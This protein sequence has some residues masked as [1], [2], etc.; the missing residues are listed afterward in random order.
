MDIG[1]SVVVVVAMTVAAL[2]WVRGEQ[3]AGAASD[4]NSGGG[5]LV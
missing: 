5:L 1:T 3:R 4:H 2:E